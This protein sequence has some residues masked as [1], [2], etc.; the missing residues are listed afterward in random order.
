MQC[1]VPLLARGCPQPHCSELQCSQLLIM[2]S[3]ALPYLM[4]LN[5]AL[6]KSWNLRTSFRCTPLGFTTGGKG[7]VRCLC[8]TDQ[9]LCTTRVS[10][11]PFVRSPWGLFPPLIGTSVSWHPHP[12][13]VGLWGLSLSGVWGWKLEG[14]PVPPSPLG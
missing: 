7:D 12:I 11:S 6:P 8:A 1:D 9:H 14:N 3:G 4:G 5:M 13:L 10:Q 2:G